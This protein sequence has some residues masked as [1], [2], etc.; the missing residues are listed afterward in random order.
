MEIMVS[1]FYQD[2]NKKLLHSLTFTKLFDTWTWFTCVSLSNTSS[3]PE[4]ISGFQVQGHLQAIRASTHQIQQACDTETAWFLSL[5]HTYTLTNIHTDTHSLTNAS[6][7]QP[8]T[9]NPSSSWLPEP[10]GF[11]SFGVFTGYCCCAPC[12]SAG[13]FV[14]VCVCVC[15]PVQNVVSSFETGISWLNTILTFKVLTSNLIISDWTISEYW[16]A[17][18]VC[19][20][21]NTIYASPRYCLSILQTGLL[22]TVFIVNRFAYFVFVFCFLLG[23]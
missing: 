21:W 17:E 2:Y 3:L 18:I 10:S 1:T 16:V 20:L 22:L 9:P 4:Q 8:T 23:I 15:V 12:S 5:L 6:C 14:C 7:W 19:T 11:Q 13:V